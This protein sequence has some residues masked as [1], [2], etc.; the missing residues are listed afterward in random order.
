MRLIYN[1]TRQLK[2]FMGDDNVP[3]YAILSHTW[4][5]DEVVYQDMLQPGVEQHEGY[6]KIQ[7]TCDRALEEGL[8][9]A[10]V[11]T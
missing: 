8:E 7:H 9:W 5:E 11:D 2:E 1:K 10:W 3:P 6:A 4:G